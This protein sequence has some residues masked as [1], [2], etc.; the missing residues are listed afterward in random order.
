[1]RHVFLPVFLAFSIFTASAAPAMN[2]QQGEYAA[3]RTE[4]AR[5]FQ[6]LD[7]ASIEVQKKLR[8]MYLLDK[9]GKVLTTYEISLGNQPVGP[10]ER[11]GDGKTPE[12]KYHISFRNPKSDY[13]RSLRISYPNEEDLARAEK[14]GVSPGGDIYIHGKPNFKFW[15]F[16]KYNKTKD[17]TNGCI[18]VND[19]DMKEMWELVAEGTPIEIKP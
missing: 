12:G 3:A 2:A 5:Q 1:M 11:E 18:A 7:V 17:W 10:K 4:P 13:Y 16:W 15:M 8:R 6:S 14:M 19:K 9:D